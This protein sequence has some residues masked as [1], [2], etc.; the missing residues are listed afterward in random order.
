MIIFLVCCKEER[1]LK[2]TD[3][4][5]MWGHFLK[6]C[7]TEEEILASHNPRGPSFH[8]LWGNFFHMKQL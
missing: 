8:F 1:Y 5:W 2:K 3:D 4:R 6:F 7:P